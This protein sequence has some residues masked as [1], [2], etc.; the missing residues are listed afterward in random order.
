MLKF[1][2]ALAAII[3]AHFYIIDSW[4]HDNSEATT[5]HKTNL[6]FQIISASAAPSSS[7]EAS[8]SQPLT[9]LDNAGSSSISPEQTST[10]SEIHIKPQIGQD[11]EKAALSPTKMLA[12]PLNTPAPIYPFEAKKAGQQGTVA[13]KFMVNELGTVE[14][15]SVVS[16][17]GYQLLDD[18]AK[19]TVNTWRF[20]PTYI[21]EEPIPHW[22]QQR[23]IFEIEKQAN[24]ANSPQQAIN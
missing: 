23:V 12:S 21:N 13:I 11:T 14:S 17:S 19:Q 8:P 1:A 2:L 10:S 3:I 18:A 5:E 20:T 15:A 7:S 22:Y 6:E 24:F 4:F 16:S 9:Q